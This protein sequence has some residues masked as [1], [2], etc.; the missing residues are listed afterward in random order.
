MSEEKRIPC[1]NCEELIMSMASKCPF[2]KEWIKENPAKKNQVEETLKEQPSHKNSSRIKILLF[3]VVIGLVIVFGVYEYNAHQIL[4]YAK[5]LD[6]ESLYE[7][8]KV[9]Y[10]KI[11]E[12]YP[13]SIATV[14]ANQ[15]L[16]HPNKE[17]VLPLRTAQICTFLLLFLIGIKRNKGNTAIGTIFLFIIAGAFLVVQLVAYDKLDVAPAEEIANELMKEPQIAF[18]I[19]YALILFTGLAIISNPASNKN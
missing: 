2:C 14:K 19:S 16:E 18:L 15:E 7:T 12:D 9:A 4:S 6:G 10:E 11:L 17:Y 1:P 5:S 13:L 8:S 3:Y